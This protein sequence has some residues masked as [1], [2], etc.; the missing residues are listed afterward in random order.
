[1]RVSIFL[2]SALPESQSNDPPEVL[3][4]YQEAKERGLPDGSGRVPL[5]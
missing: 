1:M 2:R 4:A 3:R 5:M